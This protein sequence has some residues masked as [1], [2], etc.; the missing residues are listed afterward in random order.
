[1]AEVYPKAYIQERIQAFRLGAYQFSEGILFIN[2]SQSDEEFQR[3]VGQ[4]D[5]LTKN[6]IKEI[7]LPNAEAKKAQ[8]KGEA[9]QGITTTQTAD[10]LKKLM[11]ARKEGSSVK[12]ES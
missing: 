3:L 6:S 1:M 7:E 11:E 2:D 5:E 12:T 8:I 4:C 9:T 10:A